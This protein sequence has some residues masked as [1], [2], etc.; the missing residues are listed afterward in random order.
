MLADTPS[1]AR[2]VCFLWNDEPSPWQGGAFAIIDNCHCYCPI[3]AV[4]TIATA[5]AAPTFPS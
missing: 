5:P 2:C 1:C 3:I 4:S